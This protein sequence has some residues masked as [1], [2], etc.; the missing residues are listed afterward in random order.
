[1][2]YIPLAGGIKMKQQPLLKV[3]ILVIELFII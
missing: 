1:M 2:E 3:M